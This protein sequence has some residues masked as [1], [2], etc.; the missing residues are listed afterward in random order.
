MAEITQT[1]VVDDFDRTQSADETILWAFDGEAL[2]SDLTS[3]NAAE[4]RAAVEPF[5]AVARPLGKQKVVSRKSR[6]KRAPRRAAA[7]A[8]VEEMP[9]YDPFWYRAKRNGAYKEEAAKKAYRTM[10]RTWG[11][12]NGFE[13]G[14]RISPELVEAFETSRREN[15][16]PVG[17]AVVGLE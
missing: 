10:A 11:E 6:T 7:V 13:V 5:L 9:S 4:F 8:P 14:F 1:L 3:E 12:E 2:R 17:P 15:G 16:L